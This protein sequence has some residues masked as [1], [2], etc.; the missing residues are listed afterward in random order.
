MDRLAQMGLE[1]MVEQA[2]HHLLLAHLLPMPVAVAAVWKVVQAV[3]VQAAPVVAVMGV[4]LAMGQMALQTPEVEAVGRC[5][6]FIV[7]AQAAPVS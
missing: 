1:G 4:K 5:V 3:L 2:L 7:A 6:A